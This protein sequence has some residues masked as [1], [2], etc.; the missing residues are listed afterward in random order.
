[1][2]RNITLDDNKIKL[3][4]KKIF[5]KDYKDTVIVDALVKMLG[6]SSL[7][8]LIH[9][10]FN[11]DYK[12]LE[13]GDYVKFK[14]GKYDY[15]SHDKDI[16]IDKGIMSKDGFMYGEVIG[17]TGYGN[18][19]NPTHYK[20]KVCVLLCEEDQIIMQD[21]EVKTLDCVKIDPNDVKYN[22]LMNIY[23]EKV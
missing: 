9:I 18:E 19:F 16:M 17:D 22:K 11:T 2:S 5:S 6:D 15:E 4:I 8:M 14:P 23:N 3:L 10:M 20:M 21:N 1:M 13:V 12:L 7:D